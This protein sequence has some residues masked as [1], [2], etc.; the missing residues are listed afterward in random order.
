MY[1]QTLQLYFL[2]GTLYS[3]VINCA[4]SS[5][6]SRLIL[7]SLRNRQRDFGFACVTMSGNI[8]ISL[9][10]DL[11]VTLDRGLSH[12]TLSHHGEQLFS[13]LPFNCYVKLAIQRNET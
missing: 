9:T 8:S 5:Q 2:S 1:T 4:I 7:T 13:I 3:I 10:V 11:G 12:D 6:C